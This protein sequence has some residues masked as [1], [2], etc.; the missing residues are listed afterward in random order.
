MGV[1]WAACMKY[2]IDSLVANNWEITKRY[3]ILLTVLGL[4][5]LL[6][7]FFAGIAWPIFRTSLFR[8]L[9]GRYMRA[10]IISDNNKTDMLGT[11]KANNIIQRG[12]DHWTQRLSEIAQS[13]FEIV[14]GII[15]A[16]AAIVTQVWILRWLVSVVLILFSVFINQIGNKYVANLRMKRRDMFTEADRLIVRVI[17]S[18]Q[19]VLQNQKTEYEIHK[20]NGLFDDIKNISIKEQF[21]RIWS[22]DLQ[23]I[24]FLGVQV[25]LLFVLAWGVYTGNYTVGT[26]SMVWMLVNQINWRIWWINNFMTN[27]YQ[28]IVY[29]Q[30]L[31][32]TFDGMEEILWYDIGEKFVYKTGDVVFEN[33]SYKYTEKEVVKDLSLHIA[34]QKK[35]AFVGVSGS[36]KSTIIKLIWGFIHPTTWS[37]LVDGQRLPSEDQIKNT[38]DRVALQTYYPM[39]G[40]LSQ[41][42]SVFDGTVRE[43]LLYGMQVQNISEAKLE[44]VL[45]DAQC[46]FILEFPDKLDTEIWEKGIRLSGGQ[47][48]RLAIA[49]IMLKDPKIVLLDEPT[50]ALDSFSEEEVTKAL[51][52]LFE[53]RTVVII[54]HRLQT[55][56]KADEILVL[57]DGKLVERGTHEQLAKAKGEYARMLELQTW[58]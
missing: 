25:V 51:N 13:F 53:W 52:N 1:L 42:P 33:I 31:W 6:L 45:L 36:W 54:A 28:S 30:K 44:R 27:Y 9:Y 23:Q 34:W 3:I 18:K 16:F 38:K 21:K 19:E 11:G 7:N 29:I 43:N 35:T 8:Q 22:N 26:L 50:S 17:M 39:I 46:H 14:I 58:F 24:T 41:E 56:K 32:D 10:Y 49:K 40:Y 2:V 37:I 15:I 5:N 48:Q 47:R 4:V 20:M 12:I 57:D 55:V